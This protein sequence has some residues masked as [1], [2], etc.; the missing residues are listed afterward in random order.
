MLT[1]RVFFG[2]FETNVRA[3]ELRREGVV[4][5]LQDLPFRL[6]TVLLEHPGEV[7]TRADLAGRLWGADTFV[8]AAAGLNTAVA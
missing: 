1:D 3:G 7:M 6:L 4:I 5:P 2:P 8:D